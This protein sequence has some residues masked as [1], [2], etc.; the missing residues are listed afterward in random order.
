MSNTKSME[1]AYMVIDP[2]IWG[3]ESLND[4]E[5]ICLSFIWGFTRVQKGCFAPATW[6]A[7]AFGWDLGFTNQ[8]LQMLEG[9][10]WIKV[11]LE[12]NGSTRCMAIAIPGERNPCEGHIEDVFDL[13]EE[14]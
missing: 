14:I 10:G 4:R 5:K 9:R 3:D 6:I 1:P 7:Q 13:G 8:L 2:I 11:T 12:Y